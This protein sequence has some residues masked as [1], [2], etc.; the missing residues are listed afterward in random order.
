[1]TMSPEKLRRRA[2]SVARVRELARKRLPGSVF[3]F[4]D[5]AAEDERTLRRSE[6]AYGEIELLPHP[7]SGAAER[8]LSVTLLGAKLRLPVIIG[9]TGLSGLMWPDGE[10][11][12]ARA[13]AAAGTAFIL[14]H[15]SMCTLEELAA[16]GAAPRWMQVFVYKDRGFTLEL[17]ERAAAAGYDG[18]VLTI[19]NQLTGNR[20]RDI[21]NGFTVPPRLRPRASSPPW[22]QRWAGRGGCAI[23][24]AE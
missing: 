19:D 16:T 21:R 12:A 18:L 3:D 11:A 17:T 2:Y 6:E 24:S 15:G 13:A 7:L 23:I 4:T 8:D 10:Q 20:E 14:S 9:P 1:M 22:P 5:G